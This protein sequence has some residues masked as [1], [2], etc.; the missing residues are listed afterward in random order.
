MENE[1]KVKNVLEEKTKNTSDFTTLTI[2]S[3]TKHIE[4]YVIKNVVVNNIKG[5]S[6]KT[7]DEIIQHFKLNI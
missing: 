5:I 4:K 2:I 3:D 7:L 6:Y 1:I